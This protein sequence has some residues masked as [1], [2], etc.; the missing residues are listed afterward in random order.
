LDLYSPNFHFF[1]DFLFPKVPA[2]KAK[3][4]AF[5]IGPFAAENSFGELADN[6]FTFAKSV[7]GLKTWQKI[8]QKTWAPIR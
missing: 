1:R 6:A 4:S 5:P 3:T 7:V 8:W 2:Y